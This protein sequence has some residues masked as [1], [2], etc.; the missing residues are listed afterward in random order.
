[1]DTLKTLEA[2]RAHF[3][4]QLARLP[5]LDENQRRHAAEE[6]SSFFHNNAAVAKLYKSGIPADDDVLTLEAK[7]KAVF[8]ML[9]A[10]GTRMDEIIALYTHLPLLLRVEAPNIGKRIKAMAYAL[11]QGCFPVKNVR[12]PGN[13][14]EALHRFFETRGLHILLI[15][16]TKIIYTIALHNALTGRNTH[17]SIGISDA[18]RVSDIWNA[19]ADV[20]AE[21]WPA[22]ALKADFKPYGPRRRIGTA[23]GFM[24]RRAKL[25]AHNRKTAPAVS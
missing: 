24:H 23:E 15:R 20:S 10:D 14:T 3:D 18:Q 6:L 12:G 4:A 5:G 2:F 11:R 17:S 13:T 9:H 22:L 25:A 8:A 19:L 1:M 16:R 21:K 7:A